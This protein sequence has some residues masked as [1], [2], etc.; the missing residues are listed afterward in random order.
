MDSELLVFATQLIQHVKLAVFATQLVQH[1]VDAQ[2]GTQFP[3]TVQVF[4]TTALLPILL[5]NIANVLL[6]LLGSI[7]STTQVIQHANPNRCV[8]TMTLE[9]VLLRHVQQ[10]IML[11]ATLKSVVQMETVLNA[12]MI[13]LVLKTQVKTKTELHLTTF[14]KPMVF[15]YY[16]KLKT[17][18]EVKLQEFSLDVLGLSLS[19]LLLLSVLSAT[20]IPT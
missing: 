4:T 12:T 14:V 20:R 8:I 13:M 9:L 16:I 3:I 17:S 15:A 5:T 7:P 10:M 18:Q 6:A 2:Q 1:A 19:L 11:Y